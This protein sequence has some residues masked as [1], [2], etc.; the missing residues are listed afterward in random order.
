MGSQ[1]TTKQGA[2]VS[3]DTTTEPLPTLNS[4]PREV[5]EQLRRSN[6]PFVCKRHRE[7]K[8]TPNSEKNEI[9]P[10]TDFTPL[11]AKEV[12]LIDFSNKV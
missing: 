4:L 7:I 5:Q 6:Y 12:K 11:P 10:V 2:N 3:K 9:Q 1:H 8:K